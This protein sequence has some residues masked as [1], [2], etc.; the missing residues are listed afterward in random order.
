MIQIMKVY[1]SCQRW[2]SGGSLEHYINIYYSPQP[3][4]PHSEALP[5]SVQCVP[6]R[7]WCGGRTHSLGGEG[8]GV[9]LLED[10]R[11]S[12][13]LYICRYFVVCTIPQSVR[14]LSPPRELLYMSA[15]SQAR[16]N[17]LLGQ[18]SIYETILRILTLTQNQSRED[19]S[20]GSES[21]LTLTPVN[22][23]C[24]EKVFSLQASTAKRWPYI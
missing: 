7:L 24:M 10:V 2:L 8:W 1:A 18:A 4:A 14:K 17:V 22:M 13:V 9:N 15:T 11:H 19:S 16:L 21:T 23:N 20:I 5:G 6:P 12:S 3:A